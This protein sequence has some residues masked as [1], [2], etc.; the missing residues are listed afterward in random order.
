MDAKQQV[1]DDDPDQA[2]GDGD[3]HHEWVEHRL[4]ECGK[5]KEDDEERDHSSPLHAFHR[6]VGLLLGAEIEQSVTGEGFLEVAECG[7]DFLHHFVGC[8]DAG[9]HV[10]GDSR[11][12]LHIT[13]ANRVKAAAFFDLCDIPKIDGA[14]V[15]KRDRQLLELKIAVADRLRVD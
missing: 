12:A 11:K 2:K 9:V 6:L 3:H 14:T 8:D 1:A 7:I 15:F 5:N 4:E 13:A 10:G